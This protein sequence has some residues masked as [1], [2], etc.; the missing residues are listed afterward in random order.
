MGPAGTAMRMAPRGKRDIKQQSKS[1]ETGTR[2]IRPVPATAGQ[3]AIKRG[4]LV[5]NPKKHFQ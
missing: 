5:N 4:L 2:N 1:E 3:S